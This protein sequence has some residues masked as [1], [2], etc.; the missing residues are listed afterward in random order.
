MNFV[1]HNTWETIKEL[2]Q[3]VDPNREGWAIDV[4]IGDDDYYFEWFNALGYKTI[5]VEPLPTERA[6]YA[7]IEHNVRF[8]EAAIAESVGE[9]TMYTARNIHSLIGGLWGDSDSEIKTVLTTTLKAL[10]EG[11][12]KVTALKLDIEGAEG[13]V[14]QQ[15][16]TNLLPSVL[17]F[18][19]GGVWN[20][21]T[22]QGPWS[23]ERQEEL[24]SNLHLL[25][26]LGY[27]EA[28]IVSSGDSDKVQVVDLPVYDAD[29]LF[30]PDTNWGNIVAWR[31]HE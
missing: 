1:E 29:A 12:D 14:L 6:R 13:V 4:G 22:M 30:A 23:S 20:R 3:I 24:F 11:I 31:G 18:E 9:A 25:S 19:F 17:S 21:E 16:N 5:A 8:V 27:K 10:T 28:F 26:T 15:I 7:L 2:I